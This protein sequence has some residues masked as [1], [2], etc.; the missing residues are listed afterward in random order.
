MKKLLS[1]LL[2]SGSLTQVFA[3][4]LAYAYQQALSYN[5]TYLQQIASSD[6]TIEQ[7]NIAL[8]KLLP[9]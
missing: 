1:V 6:A 4:D 8:G 3:Y 5:A 2:F 7:K 9:V